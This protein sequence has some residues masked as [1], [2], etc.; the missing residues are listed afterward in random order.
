M[1]KFGKS[2]EWRIPGGVNKIVHDFQ[3]Y[4]LNHPTE[5]F[6]IS[7][8][9]ETGVDM[10][11]EAFLI[12]TSCD[13]D[14]S[15]V[16]IHVCTDCDGAVA[17]CIACERFSQCSRCLNHLC[18]ACYCRHTQTCWH[19]GELSTE[20]TPPDMVGDVVDASEH[21]AEP[22]DIRAREPNCSHPGSSGDGT[23]AR[24]PEPVSISRLDDPEAFDDLDEADLMHPR[25]SPNAWEDEI[26][27]LGNHNGD[28]V[29]HELRARDKKRDLHEVLTSKSKRRKTNENNYKDATIKLNTV[30]AAASKEWAHHI[31]TSSRQST[32]RAPCLLEAESTQYMNVHSSHHK[33]AIMSIVFCKKCG[34]WAQKKGPHNDAAGKLSRMMKGLHPDRKVKKWP[35]GLSSTMIFP[36]I[37]LD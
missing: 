7:T 33:M 31:A 9:P 26:A 20:R 25:D 24:Q 27:R 28:D 35:D 21:Q 19:A 30:K 2:A 32:A 13:T 10:E 29:D 15:L 36:P 23:S 12:R 22:I 11:K 1:N 14:G 34:Y 4:I 5:I 37:A 18:E 16:D 3:Q 6:A 8:P 17:K